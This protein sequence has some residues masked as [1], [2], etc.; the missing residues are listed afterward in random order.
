MKPGLCA[1]LTS[2]GS[3]TLVCYSWRAPERPLWVTSRRKAAP[4]SMSAFGGKADVNH[5]VGECPLLA[6]SGHLWHVEFLPTSALTD[7]I[8]KTAT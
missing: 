6:I 4:I 8:K 1:P 7:K 5:C 3:P 2:G